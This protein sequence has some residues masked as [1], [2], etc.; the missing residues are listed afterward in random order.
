MFY[1]LKEGRNATEMQK[2]F[3]QCMEQVLWLIERFQMVCK[4]LCWG[5]LFGWC[6]TQL[7]R[8]VE[9]DSDQIKTL[10][11]NN[12]CYTTWEIAD[13]LKISKSIK[14]LVKMKN[15]FFILQPKSHWFDSQLG[16]MPGLWAKFPVGDGETLM[17]LSLSFSLP[18]PLSKNKWIKSLKKIFDIII[19]R[20]M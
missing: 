2:R 7:G 3:V 19:N 13:I 20:K 8:P 12:Q 15:V 14:F 11:V 9:V 17:F 6:S 5:F 1:Y 4:V 18:S 16:H 10:I